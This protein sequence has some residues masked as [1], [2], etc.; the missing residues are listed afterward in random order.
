MKIQPYL[1]SKKIQI[2]VAS[3]LFIGLGYLGFLVFSKESSTSSSRFVNVEFINEENNQALFLD[4]DNDGLYDWEELLWGL[5]PHDPYSNGNGITDKQYV[6]QKQK[7]EA[8]R[9]FGQE[10]FDSN[11]SE[12]EKLGR[13]LYTAL[14]AISATE[15]NL[16]A[17]TSDRVV[18]NIEQQIQ[19]LHFGGKIYLSDDLSV[20]AST[21]A[22]TKAYRNSMTELFRRYPIAVADVDLLIEASEQPQEYRNS[23]V[24]IARKYASYMDTLITTPVP[25]VVVHR[26]LELM[27]NVGQLRSAFD[28]LLAEQVDDIVILS[29]FLQIENIINSAALA[30]VKIN[31][32]FTLID[33]P[34]SFAGIEEYEEEEEQEMTINN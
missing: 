31:T 12:S 24:A 4:S 8:I 23:L 5:D 16:D 19:S 1:P 34:S 9:I 21:Q 13:S 11:L 15:G 28:N 18:R 33:D 14:L 20:V 3:L 7:N 26:H 29:S 6:E 30:V 17:V 2:V 27:N 10:F 25:D 22:N 32:F